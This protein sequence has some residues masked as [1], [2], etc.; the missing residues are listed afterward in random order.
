M[1]T[2][3]E[4]KDLIFEAIGELV[5]DLL[6]WDRKDDPELPL[7]MIEAAIGESNPG[8]AVMA[9]YFEEQV[10]LR[11]PVLEGDGSGEEE[12][13]RRGTPEEPEAGSSGEGLPGHDSGGEAEGLSGSGHRR[14]VRKNRF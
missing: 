11:V 13:D 1:I 2:S 5:S 3:E 12:A 9:A 14:T 7:G 4:R 8:P 6:Y 10:R